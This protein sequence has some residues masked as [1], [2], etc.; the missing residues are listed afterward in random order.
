MKTFNHVG[1]ILLISGISLAAAPVFASESGDLATGCSG[2]TSGLSASHIYYVSPKGSNS[3]GGSSF[4]DAMDFETALSTVQAGEMVLLKAGTYDIDYTSGEKNTITFSKS[5][6]SKA[7]I[8]VVTANC[9]RAVFDFSFPEG[10]WVQNSFGFYVT[11]DYWYFKGISIT[12][13]G[14]HG[15]YITG[16]HNT[17]E[18]MVFYNNR[19]TGFEINKGGS[20]TTVLNSDAYLNYDPKKHGSMADGFGAKQKQG[21]GNIFIGCRAWKNSDDGFDLYDTDQKVVIKESWA[22]LNGI[23]YWDD[24]SFDGNGNGF[25]L[26]GKKAVGNHT[27]T[28]SVAFGNVNK[29]FDQ[30]NNAGGVA[31]IN[32]TAYQNG[33]NYG[34][35][36]SVKSGQ[37]HDFHNNISLSGDAKVKNASSSYNS[38]DSG[39]SVSSSDFSSLD[40]SLAT[41]TR[42]KDGSLP[43]NKLFRLKS[44][45]ALIDA[46]LA[47]DGISYSGDAPDLGAFECN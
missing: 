15:A 22:F 20:N 9:G 34:F 30:N 28:R 17:F 31:V 8:Y 47:V 12:N 2:T 7:P 14:Y 39:F 42:N 10:K 4:S 35:S 40:T 26:G 16:D 45:S 38:W 25:K 13:S 11:G 5:G 36:N 27:I 44:S 1:K 33:T 41:A 6:S 23:D 24:S 21:S 29:G 46:G 3:N 32:N 43:T 37:E 19:N 18:N